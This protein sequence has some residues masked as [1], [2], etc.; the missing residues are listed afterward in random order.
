MD[1]P[2]SL[3]MLLGEFITIYT[4][5]VSLALTDDQLSLK[6]YL[7]SAVKLL[8]EFLITSLLGFAV[9]VDK[10]LSLKLISDYFYGH[11]ST[12]VLSLSKPMSLC[13]DLCDFS[14][15]VRFLNK[16]I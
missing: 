1:L 13:F 3:S 16:V 2:N 4:A 11:I 12:D 9:A 15:C 7:F 6:D 8:N 14:S 5:I 10:L